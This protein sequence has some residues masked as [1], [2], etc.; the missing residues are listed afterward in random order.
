MKET[1]T[2]I[3]F[4]ISIILFIS[5][6]FSVS[7]FEEYKKGMVEDFDKD[8]WKASSEV[9]ESTTGEY[10]TDTKN[11]IIY[12]KDRYVWDVIQTA[13]HESGHYLW[14]EF[15][16]ESQRREYELIFDN[17][18]SDKFMGDTER[19]EL[20]TNGSSYFI[21]RY[22]EKNVR[23]DFA[24]SLTNRALKRN[25]LDKKREQFMKKYIDKL[26]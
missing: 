5:L 23:E 19:F 4:T 16:N 13:Y 18:I 26:I 1:L 25:V 10:F 17:S 14:H 22:A 11:I 21:S 9:K 7:E 24:E 2:D 3:F 15:L 8:Y 12:T 6:I 20:M